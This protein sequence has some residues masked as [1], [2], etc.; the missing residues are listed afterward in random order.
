MK[1]NITDPSEACPINDAIAMLLRKGILIMDENG[2][3]RFVDKSKGR[4]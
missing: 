2:V 3:I 4:N 1:I